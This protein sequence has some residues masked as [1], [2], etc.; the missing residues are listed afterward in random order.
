MQNKWINN[1]IKQQVAIFAI[2]SVLFQIYLSAFLTLNINTIQQPNWLSELLGD[3]VLVC[4]ED[5]FKWVS[6]SRIVKQNN[7][8]LAESESA[9][10]ISKYQCPLLEAFKYPAIFFAIFIA[11]MISWMRH[12]SFAVS[13]FIVSISSQKSYLS[14]APKQSPPAISF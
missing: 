4:S 6:M 8:L 14:L 7:Q 1:F 2:C 9:H 12:Y 13:I 5:G 3:K 11:A 10:Q